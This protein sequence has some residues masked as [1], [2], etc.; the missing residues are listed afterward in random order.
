MCHGNAA[1]NPSNPDSNT[2]ALPYLTNFYFSR[3]DQ[4]FKG[5][6]Q[7]DSIPRLAQDGG[8]SQVVALIRFPSILLYVKSILF[9][10][11]VKHVLRLA[12]Q[13][14]QQ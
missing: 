5:Y 10:Q 14:L 2:N 7:V 11:V 3:D 13:R 1:I 4:G 8:H 12:A 9:L 6:L